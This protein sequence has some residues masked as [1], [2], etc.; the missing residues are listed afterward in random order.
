MVSIVGLRLCGPRSRNDSSGARKE[1]RALEE[2][3]T[4]VAVRSVGWLDKHGNLRSEGEE[5]PAENADTDSLWMRCLQG[6]LGVGELQRWAEHGR[7]EKKSDPAQGHPLPK[8]KGLGAEHPK[9]QSPRRRQRA[10]RAA[11]RAR[12]LAPLLRS[13]SPRARAALGA[14]GRQHLLPNQGQRKGASHDADAVLARIAALVTE[15]L[16][17]PGVVVGVLGVTLAPSSSFFRRSLRRSRRSAA[18]IRAAACE[19]ERREKDARVCCSGE[20][21]GAQVFRPVLRPFSL[22]HGGR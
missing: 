20:R 11:R 3:V 16:G 2:I 22:T 17:E 6:R 13:P 18:L 7:T 10:R 15:D 21:T 12:T 14:R 4:A 5:D 1:R 8:P 19:L 9:F